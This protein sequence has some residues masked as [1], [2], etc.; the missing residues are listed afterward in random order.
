MRAGSPASLGDEWA[1]TTASESR[2]G[3]LIRR[4]L[5]EYCLMKLMPRSSGPVGECLDCPG[6]RPEN[7]MG[8]Q[9]RGTGGL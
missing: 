9:A 2:P 6:Q 8:R 3:V 5:G 1:E 4:P 7:A